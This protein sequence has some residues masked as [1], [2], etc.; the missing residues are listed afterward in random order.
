MTQLQPTLLENRLRT[1]EAVVREAGRLAADHFARRELLSI[2][3]NARADRYSQTPVMACL[4][5]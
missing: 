3:R 5:R 2:D 4:V 1:A